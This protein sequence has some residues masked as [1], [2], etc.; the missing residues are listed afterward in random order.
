MFVHSCSDHNGAYEQHL[1]IKASHA[2]GIIS[3][4]TL[5]ASSGSELKHSTELI[6]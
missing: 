5:K 2:R 3:N 1:G 6:E 4:V